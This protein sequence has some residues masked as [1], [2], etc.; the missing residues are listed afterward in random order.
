MKNNEEIYEA[1]KYAV[2]RAFEELGVDE[3]KKTSLFI[4]NQDKSEKVS[5]VWPE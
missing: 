1:L 4:S 3:F 5:H 2:E